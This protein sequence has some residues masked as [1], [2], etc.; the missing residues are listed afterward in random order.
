MTTER[1][2]PAIALPMP[3]RPRAATPH[4]RVVAPAHAAAR[5]KE[6][7]LT[8]PARAGMLVGVS[9]AVYAVS[10]AGVAGLQAQGDAEIIARR[11]P[12]VD[13]IAETRAANDALEATL[14]QAGAEARALGSFYAQSGDAIAAYEAR[15]DA[16]AALVAEVKGSAAALPTRISLPTVT[17]RGTTRSAPRTTSTTGASGKP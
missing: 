2:L 7:L 8:T 6:A 3:A 4:T 1:V 16:L 14:A 9:A 5:R 11:Q 12:Y 15:L 10:L 13:A 17:V